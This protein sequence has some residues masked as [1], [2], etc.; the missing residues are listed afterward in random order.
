MITNQLEKCE[1]TLVSLNKAI[2]LLLDDLVNVA[3]NN[4]MDENN[5][6]KLQTLILQREQ[7]LSLGLAQDAN[8]VQW[9]ESYLRA[10]LKL[11]Q[12]FQSQAKTILSHFSFALQF[13][14]KS[15]RQLNVYQTIATTK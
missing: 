9:S 4:T 13:N 15:K 6:V 2:Q 5:I 10:Q 7:Q 11:T 8:A 12:R 14:H 3:E 1:Q